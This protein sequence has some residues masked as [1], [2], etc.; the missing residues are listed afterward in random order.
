MPL[1]STVHMVTI[2]LYVWNNVTVNI[3]AAEPVPPCQKLQWT[4]YTIPSWRLQ[5][6]I[7]MWSP[8]ASQQCCVLRND[9][10]CHF[11]LVESAEQ[12]SGS[13]KCDQTCWVKSKPAA[14]C[15]RTR[16]VGHLNTSRWKSIEFSELERKLH[17]YCEQENQNFLKWLQVPKIKCVAATVKTEMW[18]WE[19]IGQDCQEMTKRISKMKHWNSDAFTVQICSPRTTNQRKWTACI[20]HVCSL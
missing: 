10:N 17:F 18:C 2:F 4:C 19:K 13:G 7:H 16:T 8:R 9:H 11:S 15:Q 3:R 14:A 1:T 20:G 12:Q 6:Y 5:V